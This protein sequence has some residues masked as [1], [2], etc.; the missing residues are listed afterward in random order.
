MNTTAIDTT[1]QRFEQIGAV[2]GAERRAESRLNVCVIAIV[3]RGARVHVAGEHAGRDIGRR[4]D[5][6]PE[7]DRAQDPD[8]LR[9]DIDA[10]ADLAEPWCGLKNLGGYANFGEGRCRR[11]SGKT[12]ADNGD[13]PNSY[14]PT[15]P[16]IPK[17]DAVV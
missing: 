12:A 1:R 4:G 17:L 5:G 8:R 10:S 16:P 9:T 15:V 3:E 7:P 14:S 11:Q 2:E 13:T 6:V